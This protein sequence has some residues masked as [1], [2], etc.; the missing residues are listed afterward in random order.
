MYHSPPYISHSDPFGQHTGTRALDDS[1]MGSL[2][3][4]QP[5]KFET[6]T[7]TNGYDNSYIIALINYPGTS[8]SSQFKN[9]H[10]LPPSEVYWAHWCAFV[11]FF[12]VSTAH[13]CWVLWISKV[14]SLGLLPYNLQFQELIPWSKCLPYIG[15]TLSSQT[16]F[17]R[18]IPV[19]INLAYYISSTQQ[20]AK[21]TDWKMVF[22]AFFDSF[23]F[24]FIYFGCL[25]THRWNGLSN[26]NT[27]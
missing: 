25:H 11:A 3:I 15:V 9:N 20:P 22:L 17:F 1:E 13:E 6:T 7:F 14:Q 10:H 4:V 23:L 16:S 18:M 19:Q 26:G 5:W 2:Q 27:L 24:P 12:F 8:H 21:L